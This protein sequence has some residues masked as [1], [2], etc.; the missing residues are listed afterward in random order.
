MVVVDNREKGRHRSQIVVWRFSLEKLD[1]RAA[2]APYIRGR[3]RSGELYDLGGHP[4]RGANN[5]GLLVGT[6][7]GAGGDAEVCQLDGA[8]LRGQD[9]GALD[10]SVYD[11]LIVE[12]LQT[13]EDLRHVNADEVL[14]ELAV[15]LAYRV[16]GAVL[17]VSI[18]QSALLS[19]RNTG[20][21]V[22]MGG[23]GQ[24]RG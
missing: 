23:E 14:R 20:I 5:L 24:T 11:T 17:A 21:S 7:E 3:G 4:V 16:E 12:V 2:H 15:C 6:G 18:T 19:H 22:F 8:I 1:H 13:L 10:V 9:V